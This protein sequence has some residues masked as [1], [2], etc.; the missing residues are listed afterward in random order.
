MWSS[1]R[2]VVRRVAGAVER[3]GALRLTTQR[4]GQSGTKLMEIVADREKRTPTARE[5][6]RVEY[7]RRLERVLLRQFAE[8]KAV[9]FGRRWI[10]KRV[11]AG[12]CARVAGA[13]A[14]GLGRDRGG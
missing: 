3:A 6:V 12:V 9:G 2:N 11:L 10:W 5:S 14:A 7:A 8:W 13:G 4:M 1:E